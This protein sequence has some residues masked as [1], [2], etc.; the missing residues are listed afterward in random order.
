MEEI[1][2]KVSKIENSLHSSRHQLQVLETSAKKS[3]SPEVDG[4]RSH[5]KKGD[6]R[7]EY[8]AAQVRLFLSQIECPDDISTSVDV[9][10]QMVWLRDNL[11]VIAN[12]LDSAKDKAASSIK[13]TENYSYKV[14][15]VGEEVDGSSYKL[16]E[17]HHKAAKLEEQSKSSLSWSE[18]KFKQTQSQIKYIEQKIGKK[19]IEAASKRVRKTQLETDLENARQQVARSERKRKHRKEDAIAGVVCCCHVSSYLE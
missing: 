14:M 5:L 19:S 12:D 9:K 18:G 7:V 16:T 4:I 1:T 6:S 2:S 11:Q 15:D 3:I 10:P 13:F 8:V 17:Y